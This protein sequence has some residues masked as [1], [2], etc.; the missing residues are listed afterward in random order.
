[1]FI[2]IKVGCHLSDYVILRSS[3][4]VLA[5]KGWEINHIVTL[6]GYCYMA[7]IYHFPGGSTFLLL[8]ILQCYTV[9]AIIIIINSPVSSPQCQYSF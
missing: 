5:K 9:K 3:M 6:T 2:E 1:V 8:Q 4:Y 7:L